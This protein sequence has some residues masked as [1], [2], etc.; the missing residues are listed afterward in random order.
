MT[1]LSGAGA[2]VL[3]IAT[4]AHRGQQLSPVAESYHDLQAVLVHRCGVRP[5]RLRSLLDPPDAQTVARTIRE[6]ARQARS[7]LLVHFIGQAVI[8]PGGE[9]HL[10]VGGTDEPAP[11][12]AEHQTLSLSALQR[13][14]GISRASS[15]V[16][17]LDV[18]VTGAFTVAPGRGF[19]V[20]GTA[21]QIADSSRTP[22][23]GALIDLLRHGDPRQP[24]ALT[25]DA[26]YEA[27]FHAMR[28]HNGPLPRR[29]TD[30]GDGNSVVALNAEDPGYAAIVGQQDPAAGPCPYPGLP[31]FGADDAELFFGRERMT[32][33]LLSAAT[34]GAGPLIL[35]GPAGS[36]KTSLLN[37]AFLVRPDEDG[38]ADRT[39]VSLTPGASPLRNL[40]AHLAAP[41]AAELLRDVPRRAGDMVPDRCSVVLIDQ[42][43]ELF[44]LCPDPAERAAFVRAVTAVADKAVV[45]LA[46]RADFYG[47]AA[48]HPELFAALRDNQVIVS[49]MSPDEQRAAIEEPAAATGWEL[50]AG[51]A[52]LIVHDLSDAGSLP[53]LAHVLRATWGRRA[54]TR[55]TISGY[56]ATGGIRSAIAT[57]AEQVY[58]SL[59]GSAR[60][61]ARRALPRMVRAVEL[62]ELLDGAPDP[63]AAQRAIEAFTD[64]RLVTR[65]RATARISHEVVQHNWPRLREWIEAD[66]NWQ[67]TRRQLDDDAAAWQEA[68]RDPALLYGASRLREATARAAESP[69]RAADLESGTATFVDASWRRAHRRRRRRELAV[70]F[71]AVLA[72]LAPAGLAGAMAFHH[73]AQ[74]AKDR[75][76][77]RLLASEA[78]ELR[79]HRPGLA[80]QLSLLAYQMDQGIGR[81]A[82][83]DS[84]KTP[85]SIND[86]QPAVDV[87]SGADG[88]TLAISTG[89][90]VT[91]RG[92]SGSG[93]INGLG[94]GPV[95]VSPDGNL[96]AAVDNDTRDALLLWD[97]TDPAHPGKITAAPLTN[98]ATALAISADGTTLHAGTSS[99]SILAWDITDHDAPKPRPAFDA[100]DAGVD[101][102]ATSPR[103]NLVASTSADGKVVLWNPANPVPLATFDGAPHVETWGEHTPHRVAFDPT[104]RVLATPGVSGGGAP[105]VWR[106]EDPRVPR[107]IPFAD[108][109]PLEGTSSGPCTSGDVTSVAF[110]PKRG[111]LAAV[112]DGQWHLVDYPTEPGTG[113]L[114]ATAWI[115]GV[116]DRGSAVFDPT[117]QR[118]R[119]ATDRGIQVWDVAGPGEPGASGFLP[120]TP[121]TGSQFAYRAAGKKQLIAMRN[122]GTNSLWDVTDRARPRKLATTP[123]PDMFT[124]EAIAL[125]PDGEI[126]ASPELYDNG[127]LVGVSLRSTSHP[128]GE[129]LGMIEDLDNGIGALAFHPTKPIL[130]VSD[131]HGLATMNSAPSSVR[132]FDLTDPA[133][134]EEIA[135][136]PVEAWQID[137]TPDGRSLTAMLHGAD[138]TAADDPDAPKQLRGWDIT[139][140][141]HPAEEWRV[142]LPGGLSA[143][144][145]YRPDGKLFAA[146]DNTG[147]LRLWPVVG[148]QPSGSPVKV[149]IGDGFGGEAPVFSPDGTRLALVA[150]HDGDPSYTTRPEIWDVST[151]NAPFLQHFLPGAENTSVYSLGFSPDGRT[152]GTTRAGA[153]IDLW[154]TDPAHVPAGLC[155][156]V[157]DPI[158]PQQWKRYLP[159]LPHDPP[160][161]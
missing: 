150:H 148:H 79:A 82:M 154:D 66:R 6:Q 4:T 120:A 65:D 95:A 98:E 123:A 135:Q 149:Q 104:G 36:G 94:A 114:A 17:L 68:Q 89:D 139:D 43:E 83:L 24:R 145:A 119:Q 35:V 131:H 113:T 152:L 157:G 121:G 103:R 56:L 116:D 140:P 78:D 3:V 12:A 80:K 33:R 97:V 18:G 46:L 90:G 10:A 61:A 99:G 130:A 141:A 142:P 15:V 8:G 22:L 5:D 31:A 45:V 101:S 143:S 13:A 71:L 74:Q 138:A 37:A 50:Q 28:E 147:L 72:L 81:R 55:L 115:D 70:V 100:H 151:P 117:G 19:Y 23:T 58:L 27:L 96:L 30:D 112:C 63:A 85:G 91:L 52:E 7:V 39:H 57:S 161:R 77:A 41:E 38:S 88:R 127:R 40:A 49:P 106:I 53:L 137:F 126:L 60:E 54:G 34:S 76:R 1:D 102:I 67:R 146:Y 122:V 14:V 155:N 51:L 20:I 128:A 69:T 11:G 62:A 153:G 29:Y 2:R 129:P 109:T 16:V 25:L 64:A 59:D 87:A 21:S 132:L 73:E 86:Q 32:E 110:N 125:A 133:H 136:L 9:L 42:L 84:Q 26:V 75:E 93:R 144:F 134:P 108:E 92:P 156:A 158:T 44:T 48:A 159:D 118:L 105:S 160:C 47:H 107:R 111:N 124:G